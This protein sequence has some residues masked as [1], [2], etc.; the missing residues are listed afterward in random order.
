MRAERP[1]RLGS[2]GTANERRCRVGPSL[3]LRATMASDLVT[4]V[5][6]D[7]RADEGD[8]LERRY[9]LNRRRHDVSYVL[10]WPVM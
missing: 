10:K 8:G 2:M 3:G 7:G 9:D 1:Y 4:F 5:R 6:E